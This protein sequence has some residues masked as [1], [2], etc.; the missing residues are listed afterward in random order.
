[1]KSP[2]PQRV[3]RAGG[4]LMG[5]G[6]LY[7]L[8]ALTGVPGLTALIPSGQP[9]GSASGVR[10]TF[11]D[12]PHPDGTAAILDLLGEFG[13]T[14]TFFVVGE[15]VVRHSALCRRMIAEG[16]EIAVHGWDHR[17]LLRVG[18]AETLRLI[19]RSA[20]TVAGETGRRPARY[21]PP[22]GVFSLAGLGACRRLSLTP[23][24]WTAWG[25]DWSPSATP[26]SVH[27]RVSRGIA[28]RPRQA[29]FRGEVRQRPATV[30]L[31]DSDTYGTFGSWRT[32]AAATRMLLRD[33]AAAGSVVSSLQRAA[34]QEPAPA[35][36]RVAV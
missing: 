34:E 14:A 5:A 9:R 7:A 27:E 25:R 16:H 10:L 12:G 35:A 20:A 21:R 4:A 8:P 24:W 22:Y 1:M 23:T 15:Q 28:A 30:L 13:V 31:H 2:A 17:C 32:T 11:D 18:P 3:W 36:P 26:R 33:W 19:A 6:G 29:G